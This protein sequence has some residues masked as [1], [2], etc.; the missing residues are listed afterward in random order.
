[1]SYKKAKVF[2]L[3]F[4]FCAISFFTNDFHLINIEKTA[5]IVALGIDKEGEL[6]EVTA[7]VAIPQ[8]TNQSTTNNDALLSAKSN[9]VYGAL[10]SISLKTGWYPKLTFCNII[11]LSKEVVSGE[12]LPII[13]YFLT[14]NRIQ[15]SAVLSVSDGKAKELL[16][17]SSPL[18]NISSFA[19]QK[20]LLR[21]I[22]RTSSVLV[23]NIQQFCSTT[24]SRSA[25]G[26]IPLIKGIESN[27][28]SKKSNSSN[29]QSSNKNSYAPLFNELL[30]ESQASSGG[31]QGKGG[32]EQKNSSTLYDASNTL[33]FSNGNLACQFTS[34]QT[35]CYNLLTKKVKETFIAVEIQEDNE[36]IFALI[37]VVDNLYNLKLKI[38]KG[39]PTLFVKLKIICENEE[40]SSEKSGG[41][42]E[43]WAVVSNKGLKSLEEKLKGDIK[44][45]IELSKNSKCDFLQINEKLY[46]TQSKH[47]LALKDCALENLQYQIE[48]ECVNHH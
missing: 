43:S 40:R 19:L 42:K 41:I 48:V 7:Q 6:L 47:Y 23:S 13:N 30:S 3:L 22:D 21:N 24:R 38:E 18:D 37:S 1:M 8:A 2:I 31:G 16:S 10:E 28:K 14:T 33:L 45:L 4:I 44:E 26:Y 17:S 29:E 20:I 15:S 12:F 11:I 39:M 32:E 46:K 36:K 34:D 5:I 27:D 9:T 35:H 25:F